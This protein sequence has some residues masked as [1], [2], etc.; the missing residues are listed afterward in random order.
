MAIMIFVTAEAAVFAE[1]NRISRSEEE[2]AAMHQWVNRALL[3]ESP[4]ATAVPDSRGWTEKIPF[5]FTFDGRS[6]AN[7][8]PQWKRS[9]IHEPPANGSQRHTITWSDEQ[10]GLEVTCEATVFSDFPAVEW[11]LRLKNTSNKDTPILQDI[12]PLDLKIGLDEKEPVIFHHIKGSTDRADDFESIDTALPSGQTISLPI[13]N[14]VSQT[15]LP[16]FN[17]ELRDSGIVGAIGWTGQWML[18]VQ[19]KGE[20]ELT[21][22]SGQQ[23]THLKLLPGESI[24][25]PRILLVH[26]RGADRMRGHNLLRQLLIANYVPRIDGKVVMP[27]MSQ[28]TEFLFNSEN[29]TTDKIEMEFIKKMPAMGLEA[30]WLDAG[31]SEGGYPNVMGSW[32]PRKDNFPDGLRPV[33]DAAH[34]AGLK[35]LLWFCPEHVRPDSQIGRD[36]PQWS[37]AQK[38]NS[39]N[40]WFPKERLFNLADPK[41]RQWLTDYLSKCISDWGIDVYRHDRGLYP[42]YILRDYD[43]PDRQGIM[44]IRYVEGLYAMWD[45]LLKRHP[46]LMID[47]SNWRATGPDLE[48]LKRSAGSWTCSEYKSGKNAVCNQQQ[49]MGLSLYVPIHA[50]IL[51]GSDPYSVRSMARF[52][53]T[54]STDTRS[55][56]FSAK[57]MKRAS[58]EVKSLRELYLGNYYPI[59]EADFSEKPWCAWQFD[60]PDLGQGFAMCFRR[61]QSPYSACEITL[62]GLDPAAKYKVTFAETYDVK[63]KRVMTGRELLHFK[64]EISQTAGSLL[65]RYIKLKK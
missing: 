48:L 62:K 42:F 50:S 34:K 30:Y 49:L 33:G 29:D 44:E 17:L 18:K 60:R 21:I 15:W 31:W 54:L 59:L 22:L 52:G 51:F 47:N 11:L 5:S 7:L 27:L 65:I 3:E 10:T 39:G 26:W 35:F 55:P 56:E 24:R 28:N 61:S 1:N 58:E 16:Y 36:Y 43:A 14:K 19:R 57:E 23:H 8:L 40:P 38:S 6:S 9:I 53:A 64:T 41:A 46:G 2:C 4:S 45:E 20:R 13:D 37:L 25:T 32:F 12:R 63:E